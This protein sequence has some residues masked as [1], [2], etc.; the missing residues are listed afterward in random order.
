[1][2][3]YA[4]PAT[5]LCVILLS[6]LAGGCT[7]GPETAA[8]DDGEA[9]PEEVKRP[10][11]TKEPEARGGPLVEAMPVSAEIGENEGPAGQPQH[12]RVTVELNDN[13]FRGQEFAVEYLVKDAGGSVVKNE[14][15][16]LTT[17]KRYEKP[18]GGGSKSFS[19]YIQTK[20]K[21]ASGA[22]NKV[23]VRVSYHGH[24]VLSKNSFEASP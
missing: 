12:R 10:K 22:V 18:S 15:V 24:D 7:S 23:W 11:D 13:F 16:V 2:K 3:K 1:M 5:Y 4:M 21:A 6:L 14:S 8:R 9:Q 17:S 19:F 20:K